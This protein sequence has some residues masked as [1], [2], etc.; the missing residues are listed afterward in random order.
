LDHIGTGKTSSRAKKSQKG[1]IHPGADDN[2]SGIC[3]LLEIAEYLADLK[4]KGL[5]SAKYDILFVAWS[6]E[7][8]GLVGSSHFMRSHS[9]KKRE[10]EKREIIAYLNLDMVGRYGKKLTLHGV[11]SSTHWK[12]L[13]QQANVPVGLNLNLQ[14]DSHIPTD[15]TSFFSKGIPILSA[16]TGLHKDYHSPTDTPEKINYEGIADCA[17][18]YSR[19]I[20]GLENQES[21]DYVSQAPPPKSRGRLTVYLGTIPDYSQTDRKGVL[22][23]GV[24]KG[25]PADLAGLQSEDLVVELSGRKVETIYDYTDAI[26]SLKAGKETKVTIIRN[27]KT[28]DLKITPSTR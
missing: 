17:K 9:P 14:N 1:K 13:I 3:A 28:L 6:G 23:S 8:I 4:R 26:G 21:I 12:K 27:G 7:E 19:L 5:L 25:G 18:L 2:A 11:G 15:T 20:K 10:G 22:L 16:F 24:S